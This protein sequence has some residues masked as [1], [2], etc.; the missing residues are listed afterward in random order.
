MIKSWVNGSTGSHISLNDRGFLYGDGF[1][2]SIALKN[3]KILL[4]SYHL[5]RIEE[6]CRRFH[7]TINFEKLE[8]DI[9]AFLKESFSNESGL[10]NHGILK[11]IITRKDTGR[12][13]SFLAQNKTKNK[14]QEKIKKNA[15][16]IFQL[17]EYTDYQQLINKREQGLRLHICNTRLSR[18]SLLAG[19]KHLNRLEQV[20]AASEFDR[21]LFDEGLMLDNDDNVIEGTMSNI[22]ILLKS[23]VL[24]PSLEFSGVEGIMKSYLLNE[25][26]STPYK[27]KETTIKLEQVMQAEAIFMSNAILG[28]CPVRTIAESDWKANAGKIN[29][30]MDYLNIG[31]AAF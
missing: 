16:I 24:T 7:L 2:T 31:E 17:F 23:E 19:L 27:V 25:L 1:F 4:W 21:E 13:Y 14:A 5:K 28:C 8:Q 6:S 3:E 22:F 18:N 26:D 9:H 11:I 20:F 10:L 15:N 29:H 12:G 30:F